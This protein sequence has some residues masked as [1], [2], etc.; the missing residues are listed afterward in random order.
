MCRCLERR[1]SWQGR[2]QSGF[3]S[4]AEWLCQKY[5]EVLK[6]QA[7]C[8]V[9]CPLEKEKQLTSFFFFFPLLYVLLPHRNLNQGC[10]SV[11]PW[12]VMPWLEPGCMG[13]M[14]SS[15]PRLLS[16]IGWVMQITIIICMFPHLQMR[17][18]ML[19]TS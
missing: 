7:P 8:T 15:D 9:L 14:P 18:V 19:P 17:S 4:N 1:E 6:R 12:G 10:P 5:R 11:T 2:E 16:P 3:L 13:V